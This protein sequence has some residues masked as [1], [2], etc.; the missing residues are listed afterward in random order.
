MSQPNDTLKITPTMLLRAYAGGVFPMSDGADSREIYWVDPKTRGIFDLDQFH[1][2][3]SMVRFLR[4]TSFS[5]RVNSDFTRTVENCANRPETWINDEILRLYIR[6]HRLGYAHSV[7]TWD[8]STM[9]GGVYGVALG[10]AFFGESMFSS[11]TNASKMALIWLVARLRLGGFKL[12]DTQFITPH[13]ASL[14]AME[15]SKKRY[16]ELLDAA[17]PVHASFFALDPNAM[18]DQVL[19]LTTQTS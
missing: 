5:V 10:G 16:R 14:G 7:E 9:V 13:L 18:P 12:F 2:S 1:V 8:G 3:R 6:L 15:I 17:L 4:K 19:H 11:R